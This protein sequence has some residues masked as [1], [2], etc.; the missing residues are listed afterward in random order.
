MEYK[1]LNQRPATHGENTAYKKRKI[2]LAETSKNLHIHPV[3]ILFILLS[4]N[5]LVITNDLDNIYQKQSIYFFPSTDSQIYQTEGFSLAARRH[6]QTC[7][8]LLIGNCS[9]IMATFTDRITQIFPKL[10]VV[11]HSEEKQK[12]FLLQR[13]VIPANKPKT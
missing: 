1:Y 13:M 4:C 12:L 7:Q 2:N 10:W 8:L 11:T 3:N 6:N 9:A 5:S